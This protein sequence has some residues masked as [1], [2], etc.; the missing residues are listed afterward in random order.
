MLQCAELRL[1]S[2]EMSTQNQK[3]EPMSTQNDR[4]AIESL[5][6]IINFVNLPER[7]TRIVT[8]RSLLAEVGAPCLKRALEAHVEAV[9]VFFASDKSQQAK[10]NLHKAQ[11]AAREVLA[12][13]L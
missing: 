13:H 5:R 10:N 7:D 3:N 2:L 9:A 1:H 12:T 4:A 11:S 6:S 8:A